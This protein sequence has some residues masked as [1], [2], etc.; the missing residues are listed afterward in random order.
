MSF[1]KP[2]GKLPAIIEVSFMYPSPKVMQSYRDRLFDL[3]P[4]DGK[5]IA[6][7]TLKQRSVTGGIVIPHWV[8]VF[9]KQLEEDGRVEQGT[10]TTGKV[11]WRRTSHR[12]QTSEEDSLALP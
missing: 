9:M 4:P 3:L 2:T 6:D 7:N 11:R 12:D 1:A 8:D 10:S 5:W